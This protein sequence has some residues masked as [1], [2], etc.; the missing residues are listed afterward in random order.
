MPKK[1]NQDQIPLITVEETVQIS[2]HHSISSDA[3]RKN[4]D[5]DKH[6]DLTSYLFI[7]QFKKDFPLNDFSGSNSLNIFK[8]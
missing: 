1:D 6:Y 7:Q 5:S 2:S 3:H 4:H 8:F